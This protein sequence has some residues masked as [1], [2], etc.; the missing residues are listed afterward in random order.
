MIERNLRQTGYALEFECRYGETL[1]ED[2]GWTGREDG[3]ATRRLIAAWC[4]RHGHGDTV[5]LRN[6]SYHQDLIGP[7]YQLW[8][9]TPA[10][11]ARTG[12]QNSV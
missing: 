3:W 12:L 10:A 6:T 11:P 2:L 8:V 1:P 7:V 4:R 5:I 9:R